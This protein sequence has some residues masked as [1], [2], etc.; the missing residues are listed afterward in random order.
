M[1]ARIY[2]DEN[3][4]AAEAAGKIGPQNLTSII[5]PIEA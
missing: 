1:N 2:R 3:R 5:D 4:V